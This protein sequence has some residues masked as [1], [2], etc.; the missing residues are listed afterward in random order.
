MSLTQPSTPPVLAASGGTTAHTENVPVVVDSGITVTDVDDTNMESGT[1]TVGTGYTAGQDVLAFTNQ[2]GITGSWSAPTLTLTGSAT[3]ANWQTAL[4]SITYNNTSDTPNT[5]NRTINF[6]VNDGNSDSNTAA[7]TVSVAAANDAPVNSVPGAQTTATN[8]AKVFSTGNGNLISITD[9][10]AAG[11]TMQVQLVSTNG[12]TTLSTLTGLTFTVGDGTADATMTFTGSFAAVNTALAGLSFNPAT[13]FNG[14]ASLQIVTSDQG[15]TGTGGT[16]TD[17][18]TVT[19]NVNSLGIFTANQDIGGPSIAGSSSYSAGTYTVSGSGADIWGASDQFQY[20]T[21]PMTDDGRLTARVVSDTTPHASAKAGVMVRNTLTSGSVHALMNIQASLGSEFMARTVDS[22]TPSH[23]N[24]TAGPNAPYWVRITRIGNIFTGEHSADGATWATQGVAQTVTMGATAYFGLAVS[25][26]TNA[27]LHTATFDNVALTVPTPP[28]LSAS[29]GTTAHTENVPVVVDSAITVTDTDDANMSS[30]TVTVGSGY[31]AGQDV[32]A[33]TN[34]NGITGSW[35]APTM[36]LTGSASKANWQTALRSIT[37][38]NTSNTPNTG[39]RTINFVVNDGSANSNT[40]AKTV[41]VAAANDAPANS[42]PGAQSTAMN[43]AKVFS[44][45]NGNLISI[46]DVDAAGG[47]MQVQLVSTNGATTLSTLTG[48]SFSVGDGTADATM[49]FTGSFAA[50]NTALSGLSFNPTTSFTGAASLQIVTADQGNTGTG[51]TLTDNDT[52]AITVTG[53]SYYDTIFGES[54]LINYYRL[55]E[56]ATSSDAMTGTAGATLQS[57]SGAIGAS[58]TKHGVSDAD[59]VLTAAGRVRKGGAPNWSTLYH[60]S[61]APA[62]ADYTV[63]TDLYVASNLANDH[64]G[65]VGRMDTTANVETYYLA[66]Y[67]QPGQTWALYRRVGGSWVWLGA[68][69]QALTPGTTYRLALD[70]TG[71]S[72]RVLVDGVQRVAVTD[73]GITAAGRGGVSFGFGGAATTVTNTTGL[74]L[75]NFGVIPPMA[76]SEGTNHGDYFGGVT[77]GQ[78]GAIAGNNSVLFDG[79]DDYGSITRQISTDFT[80][81]FWFKSSNGVGSTEGMEWPNYAPM[82]DGNIVEQQPRLRCLA[83]RGR[84]RLRG[85]GRLGW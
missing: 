82:V 18:D 17:D 11:G 49:T 72:I 65:V 43:T 75:D 50:V 20:L 77:L 13:S 19:V 81:E 16:L 46:T 69:A 73:A 23:A 84:R 62:S 41:S 26:H 68:S 78:A 74:H 48:L 63:E 34:Q 6:V 14:A 70:M 83:Q 25:A 30:G 36:T 12:A 52:V 51:G 71:T 35:S 61:G 10:D 27:A 80:I 79:A 5:G 42:V 1:V 85:H 44:S 47:T 53:S 67:E 60:A 21:V 38:N 54:S 64:A 58:W 56:D 59:A 9:V 7:K 24:G 57:R 28:A 2:N 66:R 4:R 45:G 55:G 3:K 37:Y 32:L 29:G 31:T 22:Q 33:F 76:D 40:G 15:N 39:N 8:T